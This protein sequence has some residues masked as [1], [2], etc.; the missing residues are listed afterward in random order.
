MK[1]QLLKLAM[2]W[3]QACGMA[4]RAKHRI[5]RRVFD[6]QQRRRNWKF[7]PPSWYYAVVCW[8]L[9]PIHSWNGR[10]ARRMRS[11]SA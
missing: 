9:M 8:I 2:R 5:L 3:R 1:W 4:Y 6:Y 11:A 10:M 7:G